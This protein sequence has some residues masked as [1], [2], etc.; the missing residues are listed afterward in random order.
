MDFP[1][2]CCRNFVG[3]ILD[4]F[5]EL[6]IPVSTLSDSTLA[7]RMLG[8]ETGVDGIGLKDARG[9]FENGLDDPL[10]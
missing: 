2:G 6:S 4:E 1:A 5:E 9:L 7:V 8:H 10:V 3:G